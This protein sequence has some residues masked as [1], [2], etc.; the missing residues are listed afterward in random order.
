MINPLF[1]YIIKYIDYLRRQEPTR[2]RISDGVP[3]G[4][5]EHWNRPGL[6][7]NNR[8]SNNC[9]DDAWGGGL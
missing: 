4:W 5:K 1:H 7:M 9:G 3:G 2:E 8:V 6:V